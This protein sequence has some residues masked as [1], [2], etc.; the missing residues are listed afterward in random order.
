MVRTRFG[1]TLGNQ[2]YCPQRKL[3]KD[4][5]FTSVCQEFCV[6]P[7]GQTPPADTPRQ[8]PP[9]PSDTPLGWHTHS[10]QTSPQADTLPLPVNTPQSDG[11]CLCSYVL[12]KLKK[13]KP[14]LCFYIYFHFWNN[15]NDTCRNSLI[16]RAFVGRFSTHHI[17]ILRRSLF[18]RWNFRWDFSVVF[19]HSSHNRF[20]TAFELFCK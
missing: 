10:G 4:N 6:H 12:Q 17:V 13:K 2:F 5:V 20:K 16:P 11:H 18:I 9:P 3:W 14:F 15:N 7:P 1:E 8:I 19:A